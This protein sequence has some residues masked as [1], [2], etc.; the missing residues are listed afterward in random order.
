MSEQVKYEIHT[1]PSKRKLFNP[2]DESVIAYGQLVADKEVTGSETSGY[3]KFSID[4]Q[5][6]RTDIQPSYIV[7]VAAASRYGDY[8]TGG[9]GSV[10]Y[11]DEFEFIYDPEML[12]N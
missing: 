12:E 9:A 6:R 1:S 11:L 2:N 4:I 10:L 5:Y 8:F 3:Q 7:V